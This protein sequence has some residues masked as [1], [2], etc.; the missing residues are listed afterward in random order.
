MILLSFSLASQD[1]S[2]F[3]RRHQAASNNT[4]TASSFGT[5]KVRHVCTESTVSLERCHYDVLDWDVRTY[6]A[7]DG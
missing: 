5:E 4:W 3:S 6:Q 2:I 7:L 1:I